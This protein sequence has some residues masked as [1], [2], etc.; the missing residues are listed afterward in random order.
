[1]M[2]SLFLLVACAGLLVAGCKPKPVAPDVAPTDDAPRASP[3]AVL[4]FEDN[5]DFAATDAPGAGREVYRAQVEGL[6]EALRKRGLPAELVVVPPEGVDV[7]DLSGYG[8]ALVVDAFMILPQT[9][10]QLVSFVEQGGVLVGVYEVGRFPG[11]WVD[12]WPFAEVFGLKALIPSVGGAGVLEAPAGFYQVADII[13]PTS[14]LMAG[15]TNQVNWGAAARHVWPVSAAGATVLATFPRQLVVQP[16]EAKPV[17][18]NEALPAV[19][20]FRRGQGRAIYLAVLPTGRAFG[21]WADAS[22]ALTVL[23]NAVAQAAPVSAAKVAR[24]AELTVSV[25]QLGYA[26]GWPHTGVVRVR[27]GATNEPVAGTYRVRNAAGDEVAQGALKAWPGSR[28]HSRQATLDL[29]ALREPGEYQVRVEVEGVSAE[30]PV[31][32]LEPGSAFAQLNAMMQAWLE[33]IRCGEVCHQDAPLPGGAHAAV[34]DSTVRLEDMLDLVAALTRMVERQPD[35][36]R[37]VYELERALMWCWRMR[38]DDGMPSASVR[39]VGGAGADVRA[40]DDR[41]P[42]EIEKRVSVVNA[43]RYAA[44]LA[45]AVKPARE[46]ISNNLALELSVAAER[47]YRRIREEPLRDTAEIGWR[48]WAAVEVYRLN[49]QADYLEDAQRDVSRLYARQVDRDKVPGTPVY[50]DFYADGERG[51]LSPLQY[52]RHRAAGLYRGLIELYR[53][54]PEGTSRDDMRSVLDRFAQG[55]LVNGSAL[56]PYGQFLA[57]L[58]PLGAPRPRPGNRGG[59]E[60]PEFFQVRSFAARGTPAG[61]SGL[62]ADLL[63]LA[64]VA[65]DWA[66]ETGQADLERAGLQQLNWLCGVNPLGLN[67]LAGERAVPWGLAGRADHPVWTDRSPG[68]GAIA[69]NAALLSALAGLPDDAR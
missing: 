66:R 24:P 33:S 57:G 43:A 65:F 16:G 27:G 10:A 7:L 17:E 21:G 12:P 25:N 9:R 28:W 37:L 29:S 69:P 63:T 42:R 44:V 52:E 8:A 67:Q 20:E 61:E 14:P 50:G 60:P 3:V 35:D 53:A 34:D 6:T 31:R 2:R 4:L 13:E 26:P 45:R 68:R 36:G 38:G 41:R 58:E 30:T 51:T 11:A 46:R 39:P 55:F 47:A 56:S 23:A 48:L 22:D 1:M 54:L 40:Q 19:T 15:L 49:L 5:L 62:N 18:V 59:F 64:A 32:V